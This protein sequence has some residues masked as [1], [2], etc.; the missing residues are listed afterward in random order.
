MMHSANRG[1][2]GHVQIT[3]P[4]EN[5]QRLRLTLHDQDGQ[6]APVAKIA[7]MM[8]QVALG[9]CSHDHHPPSRLPYRIIIKS[10]SSS[11]SSSPSATSSQS[12]SSVAIVI[13]AI[14]VIIVIIAITI[15]I[16]TIMIIIIIIL[17]ISQIGIGPAA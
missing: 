8:S 5:L 2:R 14:I 12:S 10:P 4:R 15:M 17:I 9:S 7:A 1:A 16:T 11:S 3:T 6:S 13:I